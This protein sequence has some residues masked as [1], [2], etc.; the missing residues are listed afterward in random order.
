MSLVPI[1][2]FVCLSNGLVG[3][4]SSEGVVKVIVTPPPG[5]FSFVLLSSS[6]KAIKHMLNELSE[7]REPFSLIH[8]RA[9]I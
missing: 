4:C 5:T 2:S 3:P 6:V 8:H 9:L 1:C 7:S